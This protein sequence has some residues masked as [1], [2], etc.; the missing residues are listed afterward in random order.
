MKERFADLAILIIGLGLLVFAFY[1]GC[2][3]SR[4]EFY[5]ATAVGRVTGTTPIECTNLLEAFMDIDDY[6]A[7]HYPAVEFTD[8][9]DHRVTFKNSF[10]ARPKK[11][12]KGAETMVIYMT[13]DP[14]RTAVIHDIFSMWF[15]AAVCL[16]FGAGFAVAGFFRLRQA[17]QRYRRAAENPHF[18]RGKSRPMKYRRKDGGGDNDEPGTLNLALAVICIVMAVVMI[19]RKWMLGNH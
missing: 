16:V 3:N 15:D 5:G 2:L 17:S 18:R 9:G 11:Y 8:K 1:Y 19:L 6:A 12:E 13:E 7:C 14:A 10:M 4:L